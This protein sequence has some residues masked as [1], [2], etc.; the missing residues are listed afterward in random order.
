MSRTKEDGEGAL[1]D[2]RFGRPKVVI[3]IWDES[4]VLTTRKRAENSF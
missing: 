3:M 1:S 4:T 2:A